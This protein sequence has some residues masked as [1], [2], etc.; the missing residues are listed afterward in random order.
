[1]MEFD[2]ARYL[3]DENDCRLYLNQALENGDPLEIQTALADI[4]RAQCTKANIDSAVQQALA[5]G[6]ADFTTVIAVINALG[7]RLTVQENASKEE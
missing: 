2:A 7:M 6:A 5:Q 1:M 3:N 4:A